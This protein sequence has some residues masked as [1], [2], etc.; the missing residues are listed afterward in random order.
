[1]TNAER[2]HKFIRTEY[3]KMVQGL[4]REPVKFSDF[5]ANLT[6][7]LDTVAAEARAEERAAI[8]KWMRQGEPWCVSDADKIER[9]EHDAKPGTG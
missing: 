7:L 6:A 4:D 3:D 5:E 2:A 1:M 8:V 9:G